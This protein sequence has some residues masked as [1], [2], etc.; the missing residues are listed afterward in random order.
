MLAAMTAGEPPPPPDSRSQTLLG[1][2]RRSV[3]GVYRAES[4][5]E[6]ETTVDMLALVP[7]AFG[8][9][10]I[11][12]VVLLVTG[13][14]EVVLAS[15]FGATGLTAAVLLVGWFVA[16]IA[17]TAMGIRWLVVRVWRPINRARA[18]VNREIDQ[19]IAGRPDDG[20]G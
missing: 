6:L 11:V 17:L 3:V 16:F 15:A 13:G 9:F 12:A 5:S 18:R 1:A 7:L 20:P 10:A 4:A 2:I 14:I 19:R 8:A